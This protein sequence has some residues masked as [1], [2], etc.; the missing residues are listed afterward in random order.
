MK[1]LYYQGGKGFGIDI[2]KDVRREYIQHLQVH[3]A[4]GNRKDGVN[5]SQASPCCIRSLQ[6]LMSQLDRD[7]IF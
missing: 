2:E 6:Q 5:P 1:V 7:I 4:H 3:P